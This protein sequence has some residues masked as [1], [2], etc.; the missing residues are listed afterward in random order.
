MCGLIPRTACGELWLSG[1][2][3]GLIAT[4]VGLLTTLGVR[5]DCERLLLRIVSVSGGGCV[6]SMLAGGTWS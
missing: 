4:L 5:S 2:G 6:C 1:D 3:Y